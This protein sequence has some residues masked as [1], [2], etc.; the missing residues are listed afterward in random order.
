MK[1]LFAPLALALMQSAMA[2]DNDPYVYD[3]GFNG[4]IVIEDRFAATTL[5][6]GLLGLRLTTAA[7]GDVIAAGIVPAAYQAAAPNNL[8][9]VRYGVNGE[10]VAWTSPSSAFS[11]FDNRYIDFPNSSSGNIGWVDDIKT[12]DGRIYVLVD[13]GPASGNR[14]V[15]IVIFTDGGAFLDSMPAFT[16]GLDETG[17][18]LL[19]YCYLTFN[20]GS[21]ICKLVATANYSSSIGRQIITMKRFV[22]SPI[23]GSL[24]VDNSFG[25]SNNG[26]MDQ[27]MPNSLCDAGTNCSWYIRSAA[28]LRT[29]TNAPTLY[30]TGTANT[31]STETDAFVIAVNGYD[32]SLSSSFGGGSGIYVNYL[33]QSSAG[34]AIAASTSGDESTDIVYLASNT[35]ES[36][37]L[38]GAVTKLRAHVTTLPGGPFTLPDF[39]W[40]N[41]GTRDIG[42]NPGSCGNVHT[43]LTGMVLDGNRLAFSGYED[44]VST[45]PDPLFAIVRVAD[46]ALTEFARAGF[47]AF[48]ADG[49]L[50]GGTA[51]TDI[52]ATGGGRYATTGYLYD[53]S[54]NNATLFGTARFASD[55]IFGDGFD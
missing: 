9:L 3:P 13:I 44:I 24:G 25:I 52:V 19:P 43:S 10:R 1:T 12:L 2:L 42:G 14:D 18:S 8:G 17:A 38:K 30:L 54:A 37:G 27:P 48:R 16:T 32:G 49:T 28:A 35:F 33:A 4:G 51:Y 47:P 53:T 21:R 26:A 46:G 41:G 22:V 11:Y 55:R 7:N 45:I 23:D 39:S 29:D 36:C 20:G 34:S 5:N 31:R 15:R 50:W 40:A 6:T